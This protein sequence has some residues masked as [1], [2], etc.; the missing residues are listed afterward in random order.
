MDGRLLTDKHYNFELQ[1]Q[2]KGQGQEGQGPKF[3]RFY[4]RQRR[5]LSEILNGIEAKL[6]TVGC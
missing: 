4:C 3:N 2:I 1:G 6:W 5:N